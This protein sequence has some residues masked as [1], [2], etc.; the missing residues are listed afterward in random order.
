MKLTMPTVACLLLLMASPLAACLW[1]FDTIKMETQRFPGTLELITGKF[2]RHSKPFYEWRIED[3]QKRIAEAVQND[4]S[5]AALYDDLAVAQEKTG[6]TE[7]AIETM[8]KKEELWPGQYTTQANLGTFYIHSGQLG[9]GIEHIEKAIEINRDAHFGREVY[10]KLLVEYVLSKQVNGELVLPL[11]SESYSDR[12]EGFVSFLLERQGMR[13]YDDKA[14]NEMRQAI[15]GVQGM[16]HF[17]NY[18]SPILLEALADL[19]I[20]GERQHN[21]LL[22]ACRAYLA[23]SYAVEDVDASEAYREKATNALSMQLRTDS[24]YEEVALSSVEAEFRSELSDA[25][26]WFD[27]LCNNEKSWINKGLNPE[28]EFE[29]TYRKA[30]RP[31]TPIHQLTRENPPT[32]P[33]GTRARIFLVFQVAA[34]TAIGLVVLGLIRLLRA[35]GKSL[36]HTGNSSKDVVGP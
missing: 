9:K 15:T 35:K 14:P 31:R 36:A 7:A 12:A 25:E 8:L 16:M 34:V 21:A 26:R 20:D 1:D 28:A 13:R 5:V 27:K 22:L 23:A 32:E 30:S 24:R 29:R 2:L 17:G 33:D 10:Q 4:E 6:Q 3:R 11:N 19:L 18:Q